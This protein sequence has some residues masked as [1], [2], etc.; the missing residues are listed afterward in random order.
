MKKKS[1]LTMF[2]ALALVGAI[3]IGATLAYLS[4]ATGAMTN[5]FT[6][7]KIKISMD[8]SDESTPNDS[9]DRTVSGNAYNDIQPGDVLKKDPTVTVTAGSADCYVFMKLTGADNLVSNKFSFG[10][11]DATKW[12]KVDAN[13]AEVDLTKDKTLD[14]IYRYYKVVNK[15]DAAQKLEPLFATVTYSIDAEELAQGVTLSDVV[16]KSCAVQSDNIEKAYEGVSA[17][18]AAY[19]AAVA[20]MN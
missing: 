18:V 8:E 7:G 10:G 1:L 16:I 19:K 14:G 4:D 17:E 11:F 6:V 12:I 5:T 2:L 20:T 13:G 3:G 9:T 15:S